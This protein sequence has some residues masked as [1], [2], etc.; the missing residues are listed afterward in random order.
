MTPAQAPVHLRGDPLEHLLLFWMY[1]PLESPQGW[2]C[3]GVTPKNIEGCPGRAGSGF[4][5]YPQAAWGHRLAPVT[6]HHASRSPRWHW[7]HSCWHRIRP[8]RNSPLRPCTGKDFGV[9][10]LRAG[11]TLEPLT[12]MLINP[13]CRSKPQARVFVPGRVESIRSAGTAWPL[14]GNPWPA[15]HLPVIPGQH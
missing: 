2:I 8:D 4:L 14:P 6:S 7:L 10:T 13:G 3:Q 1:D 9:Q 11:G 15:F 5:H 12:S